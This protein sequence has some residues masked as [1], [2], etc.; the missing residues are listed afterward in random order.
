MCA[1]LRRDRLISE[2]RRGLQRDFEVEA[3]ADGLG[4]SGGLRTRVLTIAVVGD[5]AQVAC[6]RAVAGS[7][8]DNGRAGV[9]ARMVNFLLLIDARSVSL[10]GCFRL[11]GQIHHVACCQFVCFIPLPWLRDFAQSVVLTHRR[12]RGLESKKLLC[13]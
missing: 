5:A 1:F 7:F 11:K 12:V 4:V 2:A 9:P 3:L 8:H 6:I 10:E 13:A